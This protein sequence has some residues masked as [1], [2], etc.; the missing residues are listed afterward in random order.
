VNSPL[1]S[2]PDLNAITEAAENCL[3]ELDARAP[4]PPNHLKAI[5][6]ALAAIPNG[7][8]QFVRTKVQPDELLRALV[9]EGVSADA[10]PLADGT[11]RITL[12][13]SGAVC[14]T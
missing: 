13:R 9:A 8:P 6:A 14:S 7:R 1:L 3:T 10:Q 2:S 11:W 12:R 5:L 4:T